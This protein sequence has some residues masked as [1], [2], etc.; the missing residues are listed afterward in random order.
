MEGFCPISHI[1][2]SELRMAV[3]FSGDS[4]VVYDAEHLVRWLKEFK[5]Q[6][7]MTNAPVQPG[8]LCDILAPYQ[9]PHMD[10]DSLKATARF[11]RQEGRLWRVKFEGYKECFGVFMWLI[12]WLSGFYG[13]TFVTECSI[14]TLETKTTNFACL[15]APIALFLVQ[16]VC[17][18]GMCWV[19]PEIRAR[20]PWRWLA[21]I[22]LAVF[23]LSNV[24]HV[25]LRMYI[26]PAE[27]NR[28][29]VRSLMQH[30]G[31]VQLFVSPRMLWVL[32][33]VLS[34]GG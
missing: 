16:C 22:P 18:L 12:A 6:N 27:L 24:F 20:I 21:C 13:V 1:P 25:L 29:L 26:T 10:E 19:F 2:L 30:R 9:L 28:W 4:K 5:P 17:I 7:P 32:E 14:N 33:Q 8:R 11:L 31:W 3:V 15:I 23:L 34:R